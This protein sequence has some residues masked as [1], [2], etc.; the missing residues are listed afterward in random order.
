MTR[1][2]AAVFVV[3]LSGCDAVPAPDAAPEA[4]PVGAEPAT[5]EAPAARPEPG[6]L[7]MPFTADEIRE[8]WV[9]G[10]TLVMHTKTPEGETR[11]RWT[12]VAADTEGVDIR[13][14]PIDAAGNAAGEPRDERSGWVELRDHASYPADTASLEEVTRD[15]A[16]GRLDCWLY[17]VRDDATGSE[18]EVLFAKQLPGAPVEMRMSKDGT[19][20]MEMLQVERHRPE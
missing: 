6:L 13:F 16:L 5:G 1:L 19:E 7:P 17:R 10:L 3:L 8:E 12:V 9:E 18:T 2:A 14:A 15:T 4:S 20:I 11:D